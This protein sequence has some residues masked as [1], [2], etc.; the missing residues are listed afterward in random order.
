MKKRFLILLA[1]T[2]IL[3]LNNNSGFSKDIIVTE[4][5]SI[6]DAVGSSSAGDKIIVKQ[7]MY[8]E[9]GIEITKK[10]ELIGENYPLIDGG[11]HGEIITVRA[12]GVVIKGLRIQNTGISSMK[13]NA[14]IKIE[15]SKGC[16]IQ[17]N[18]LVKQ[19]LRDIP[20]RL[21]KMHCAL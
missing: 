8:Y 2:L 13:D 12:D 7:G 14:A 18:K 1:F 9:S 16:I 17:S 21:K 4:G 15:N 5:M 6:K 3:N 10:I 11:F 19:L 20:C